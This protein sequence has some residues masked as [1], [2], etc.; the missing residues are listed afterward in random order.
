MSCKEQIINE[1]EYQP[2]K[3]V[4]NDAFHH[5]SAGKGKERHAIGE[6]FTQQPIMWIEKHFHSF[7]L[8]QAVKKIHEAQRL[9]NDAAIAE[10]LG[11]INYLAAKIIILKDGKSGMTAAERGGLKE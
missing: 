6:P 10:L 3:A 5:A 11:A 2:L 4:L 1:L 7:Q 9:G 8:G